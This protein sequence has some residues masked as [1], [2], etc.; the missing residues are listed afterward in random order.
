MA[1]TDSSSDG[2][3]VWTS[4]TFLA[5]GALVALV[6]VLAAVL[7]LSG[8]KDDP[9]PSGTAPVASTPARAPAEATQAPESPKDPKSDSVCGLPAGSQDV[10]TKA[11]PTKW[12][13]VGKIA[14]PTSPDTT[15]PGTIA[16]SGL[17][18]CYA[19]S[20]TG[21][22][23][24][25]A[26]LFVMLA[27]PSLRTPA[28]NELTEPSAAQRKALGDSQPADAPEARSQI[29]GYTLQSYDSS[30]A[31]VDLAV[32]INTT[33]SSG[34]AVEGLIRLP[35]RLVWSDGDWKYAATPGGSFAEGQR[36]ENLSGLT[37][38]SGV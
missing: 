12:K 35:V 17:R 24:A 8:G 5:S 2:G 19:H 31:V 21:A 30:T 18:S 38:W 13:L 1:R 29:A 32:R 22:L 26:N 27:T 20:P 28:L 37:P 34:A 25:G 36:L 4:L 16:D 6:V 33:T 23:Y 14:A 11:P 9:A 7:A 15:G 3:S 10:P